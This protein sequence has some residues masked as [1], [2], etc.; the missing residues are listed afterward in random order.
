MSAE[1]LV[2]GGE[3][4]LNCLSNTRCDVVDLPFETQ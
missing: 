2:I 1:R 4:A 3:L